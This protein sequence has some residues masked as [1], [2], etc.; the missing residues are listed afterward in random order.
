MGM[1]S[2]NDLAVYGT[3]NTNKHS[4]L[5]HYKFN[6]VLFKGACGLAVSCKN[7]QTILMSHLFDCCT[8]SVNKISS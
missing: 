5:W 3:L 4:M 8:S 7:M 6:T 2:L 1:L